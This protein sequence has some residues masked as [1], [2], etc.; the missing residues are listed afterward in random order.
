MHLS[1]PIFHLFVLQVIQTEANMARAKNQT[2]GR[3]DEAIALLIQNEAALLAQQTESNRQIAE[4]RLQ[5]AE[6]ERRNAE[7]FARIDER[8][9]NIE[10]ILAELV[11]MME[12]LPDAV[13]EK[14]G[15]RPRS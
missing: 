3:L 12:A 15:F 5:M 8:F 11:R 1:A 13:R 10:S 6:T 4:A 9:R 14:M 7:T 2:N